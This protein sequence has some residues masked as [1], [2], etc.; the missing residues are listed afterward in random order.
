MKKK[1]V[2]INKLS[3]DSLKKLISIANSLDMTH[4]K[5]SDSI[6]MLLLENEDQEDLLEALKNEVSEQEAFEI[7]NIS[8]KI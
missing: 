8:K 6:D 7:I 5:I 2:Q 4:P 3:I 1:K